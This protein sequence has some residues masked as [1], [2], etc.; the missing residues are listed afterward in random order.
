MS[1]LCTYSFVFLGRLVSIYS[2]HT[3]Q[4]S[5]LTLCCATAPFSKELYSMPKK[6]K[7]S[8]LLKVLNARDRAKTRRIMEAEEEVMH[9]AFDEILWE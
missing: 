1:V 2:H 7:T 6:A 3:L 8:K 5:V 9:S 4:T